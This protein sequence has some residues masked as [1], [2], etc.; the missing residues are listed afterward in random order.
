[1][2]RKEIRVFYKPDTIDCYTG[3]VTKTGDV[4]G[5][6]AQPF[7]PLGFGQFCGN[8]TDRMNTTYGCGW[9]NHFDENKILKSELAHYLREAKNNPN[10]LGVEIKPSNLSEQAQQYIQQILA[11]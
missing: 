8:V 10:W 4:F 5:F 3:V 1:M 2:K 7:H 6:N 9:R 11:D